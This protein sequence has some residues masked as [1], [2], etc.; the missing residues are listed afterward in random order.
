MG[1]N[2]KLYTKVYSMRSNFNLFY[3]ANCYRVFLLH[4]PESNE[5][6]PLQAAKSK[7]K[8]RDRL[9][10]TMTSSLIR[11]GE[12]GPTLCTMQLAIQ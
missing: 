4:K 12:N 6:S 9:I 5:Y 7:N 10:F 2:F 3:N 8:M 11:Q 1:S